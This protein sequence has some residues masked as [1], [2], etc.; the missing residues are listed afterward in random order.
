MLE[1]R[2]GWRE[3]FLGGDART[4]SQLV[5]KFVQEIHKVQADNQKKGQTQR[6]TRAFHATSHVGITNARFVVASDLPKELQLE[7]LARGAVYDAAVRLSNASGVAQADTKRDLRGIAVRISG[8]DA[9]FDLLLTNAAASHARNAKQFMDF[10]RAGAGSKLLLL[11]RLLFTVGPFEMIRILVTVL[12]QSARKVISLATEQFWSRAPY[13]LGPYALKFTFAPVERAAGTPGTDP[14]YLRADLV[15]RLKATEVKYDLKAQ[16]WLDEKRTPIE[17]GVVEWKESD[18][19]PVTLG[20]LILPTQDLTTPAAEA[21]RQNVD[22][23]EFNPWHGR[24]WFRPLGS[25]NRARRLVYQSSAAFRQTV[26]GTAP[27]PAP[28]GR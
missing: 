2:T 6:A 22:R 25:L 9:E 28:A 24:G 3:K 13:A 14:G 4:E 7:G 10:A 21:I 20:Q 5:Q 8:H 27:A 12:K 17:D 23:M 1:L 18:S 26:I 15:Q 11:P 19:A 16:F